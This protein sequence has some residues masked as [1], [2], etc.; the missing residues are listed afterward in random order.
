MIESLPKSVVAMAAYG[1]L[2][3][4]SHSDGVS[5]H[6]IISRKEFVDQHCC[7]GLG[8]ANAAGVAAT[9]NER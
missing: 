1:A 3:R 7:H 5:L 4:G 2:R 8:G 6:D 9:L